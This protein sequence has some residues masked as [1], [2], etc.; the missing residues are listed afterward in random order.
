M[1]IC[2]FIY[3]RGF[4]ICLTNYKSVVFFR[5]ICYVNL[6]Y[7]IYIYLDLTFTSV[8]NNYKL[9]I[10]IEWVLT[11]IFLLYTLPLY[12]AH[13]DRRVFVYIYIYIYA[14][15]MYLGSVV[16]LDTT[17]IE[18]ASSINELYIPRIRKCLPYILILTRNFYV[19]LFKLLFIEAP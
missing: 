7:N 8:W 17:N 5:F 11:M 18:H 10:E 14:W 13:K 1:V 4:K 15:Y 9:F 2:L 12:H 16:V 3:Y 19:P 6:N